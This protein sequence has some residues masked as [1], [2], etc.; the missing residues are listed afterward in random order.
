MYQQGGNMKEILKGGYLI[1]KNQ[2]INPN[3]N[4]WNNNDMYDY[5]F[6]TLI[7]YDKN[8]VLSI[9]LDQPSDFGGW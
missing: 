1:I 8:I 2:M 5:K 6:R 4:K 7:I 3:F 9:L